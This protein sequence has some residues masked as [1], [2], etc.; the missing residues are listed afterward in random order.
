MILS[1]S[2]IK[3][4]LVLGGASGATTG[5]AT[6]LLIAKNNNKAKGAVTGLLT[7][8][9]IGAAAGFLIKK[10]KS[11]KGLKK[12]EKLKGLNNFPRLHKPKIKRQWIEDKIE[13]RKFIKGHWEYLIDKASS[14]EMP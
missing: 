6:G 4:S 7:G 11:N 8:G 2:T 14:W 3:E 12:D 10:L 1:C 13:G 5:L 9:L